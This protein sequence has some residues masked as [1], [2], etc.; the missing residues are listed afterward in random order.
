MDSITAI[1]VFDGRYRRYTKELNEIFSEYGL[2]KHRV[3][4]EIQWLKFLFEELGFETVSSED[5]D[6]ID[7]I[8][9]SFD[10][11]SARQIKTIEKE[12]NHDVKA[13]EYY[14]K[15]KLT[16]MGLENLKEWADALGMDAY[17]PEVG[18]V[19]GL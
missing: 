18:D 7:S 19:I 10:S 11:D 2:I 13:V 4:V 17:A 3:F 1:S 9:K 6:R 8:F 12:T 14:I 16:E 5:L 15:Q